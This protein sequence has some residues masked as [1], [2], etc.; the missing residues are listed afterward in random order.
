MGTGD[1]DD[2]VARLRA[3]LPPW[4]PDDDPIL[5]G[6]LGGIAA[7]LAFT[8]DLIADLKRQT[9]IATA[10]GG[11]LDL[12]AFDYF[13]IRF[14]RRPDEAD[15]AFRP[16]I[17]KELLRPRATREAIVE[18][19]VDLTGRTPL[20]A[21]P[22]N[23]GDCGAYDVGTMAYAGSVEAVPV[24]GYDAALGGW[25]A[26]RFAYV[27]ASSDAGSFP[28]AGCWGSLD[29]PCQIFVTA[30]RPISRG[31]PDISGFDMPGAGYDLGPLAYINQADVDSQIADAEIYA[32]LA[33][34]AAAGVTV[35]TAIQN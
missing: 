2:M 10:T 5:D 34:T 30:F 13:G 1:P 12:I 9:R 22:W 29:Y 26:G 8:Y 32:R 21:E 15:D 28:G 19:L 35:W 16:R 4:F 18:A 14:G 6:L 23:P 31:I 27:V 17:L 11:W 33:E 24:S 7:L 3:L 20:I 25:D